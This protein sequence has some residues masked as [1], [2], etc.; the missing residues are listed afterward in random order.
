MDFEVPEEYRAMQQLARRFVVDE[1]RPLE[2][3]VEE[4]E[5]LPSE[6]LLRLRDRS[7]ELGLLAPFTPEEEGGG[8][9]PF[10]NLAYILLCEIMGSTCVIFRGLVGRGGRTG[11]SELAAAAEGGFWA[12]ITEPDA[13][14][15]QKGMKTTA[16]KD[17]DEWVINGMK[18]LISGVTGPG[19]Q[20]MGRQGL[21]YAL[22]DK[23]NRRVTPFLVKVGTP[24][25][26]IGR[27]QKLMGTR[28]VF[29]NE[30]YFDDCRVPDTNQIGGEGMGLRHFL[31]MMAMARLEIGAYGMGAAQY[32]LDRCIDYAAHR[33]IFG[34]PLAMRQAIQWMITD[35]W[36]EIE[37]LRWL[38][39]RTAWGMDQGE[40]FR[41]GYSACK[42][43]GSELACQVADRAIQIHGGLGYTTDLPF[44]R[45]WR[46]YRGARIY[47][48]ATEVH[49]YLIARTLIEER[50]GLRIK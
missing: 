36:M 32:C 5:G 9:M 43:L 41:M 3:V 49:K 17:G 10:S 20:P 28:G 24:G 18:H 4:N 23:E 38:L 21:V 37:Q 26:T 48:G 15:D 6:T 7:R 22:T 33:V 47:E 11:S 14:S 34:Q 42:V 27:Q 19:N 1:L 25:F 35:S 44:E 29:V 39:Y 45:I 12:A 40:D 50:T 46:D 8:G 31:S 13:G 30:L 2:K 16:I